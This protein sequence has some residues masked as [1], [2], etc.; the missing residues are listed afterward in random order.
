M[1]RVGDKISY[2]LFLM[3]CL[4]KYNILKFIMTIC[5]A[6]FESQLIGSG[7]MTQHLN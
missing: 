6:I 5:L 7:G 2:S 4:L 3:L 1:S